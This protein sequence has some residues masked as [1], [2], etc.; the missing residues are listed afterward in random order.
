VADFDGEIV[1]WIIEDV[2]ES[3][4]FN[5]EILIVEDFIFPGDR[6]FYLT[7]LNSVPPPS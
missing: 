2:P 3:E 6:R 7:P 4:I 1:E 5:D